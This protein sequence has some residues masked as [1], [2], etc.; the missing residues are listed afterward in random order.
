MKKFLSVCAIA[1]IAAVS[2]SNPAEARGG[3]NSHH[4]G[5]GRP[6]VVHHVSHRPVIQPVVVHH[7]GGYC[8]SHCNH[9]RDVVVYHSHDNQAARIAAIAFGTIGAAALV[10]AIV[11]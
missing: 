5:G 11:R 7:H 6:Q 9:H 8:N 2:I 10:S 4:H 1:T 3:R